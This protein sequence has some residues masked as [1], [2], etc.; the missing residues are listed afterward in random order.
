MECNDDWL[1]GRKVA[2]Q[3]R[4]IDKMLDFVN[5]DDVGPGYF[6]TNVSQKVSA[7]IS[8]PPHNLFV[9]GSRSLFLVIY[10]RSTQNSRSPTKET[11][12]AQIKC[13]LG[14]VRV[15]VAH[16]HS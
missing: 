2:K 3:S 1:G 9:R 4:D 13:H 8:Q 12:I 14:V 16:E 10:P 15:F 5:V 6:G 7:R 11:G